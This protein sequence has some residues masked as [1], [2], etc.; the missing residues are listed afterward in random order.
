MKKMMYGGMS[1]KKNMMG[2][3]RAMYGHGGMYKNVQDM[4]KHC[5]KGLNVAKG[6]GTKNALEVSISI[7]KV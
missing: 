6:Y 1:K 2:G 3:G 5:Y 7:E 4:E